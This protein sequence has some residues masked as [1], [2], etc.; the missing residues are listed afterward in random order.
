MPGSTPCVPPEVDARSAPLS[1][2]LEEARATLADAGLL[3]NPGAPQPA[4]TW[5]QGGD[6]GSFYTTDMEE[7]APRRGLAVT[8]PRIASAFDV[9]ADHRRVQLLQEE[10]E[11]EAWAW[12]N[13]D[14]GTMGWS[15]GPR[16]YRHAFALGGVDEFLAE[17]WTTE[18][19]R[20]VVSAVVPSVSDHPTD[21]RGID[22]S[23]HNLLMARRLQATQARR[24]SPATSRARESHAAPAR[25]SVVGAA[26]TRSQAPP[27]SASSSASGDEGGDSEGEPP[28]RLTGAELRRRERL[29]R[30]EAR[31]RRDDDTPPA[32]RDGLPDWA[33]EDGRWWW[34]A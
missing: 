29:R 23:L 2:T 33:L 28:P 4:G 12:E 34:A 6:T 17:A 8:D 14:P 20:T 18:T 7:L 13:F 27:G 19:F 9:Y 11:R 31:Y 5:C 24:R 16:K 1:P 25:R 32:F 26:S 10:A 22:H 3:H 15:S 21:E 30:R